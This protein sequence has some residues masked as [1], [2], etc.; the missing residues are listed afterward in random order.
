[1]TATPSVGGKRRGAEV[2]GSPHGGLTPGHRDTAARTR[3]T[4]TPT[5][6]PTHCHLA[7]GG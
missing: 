4:R 3:I 1:V 2:L 7:G 5:E 6:A